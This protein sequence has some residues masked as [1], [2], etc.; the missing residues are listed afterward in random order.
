MIPKDGYIKF[1]TDHQETSS[2]CSDEAISELLQFRTEVF[3]CGW[4]G[5]LPDGVGFGNLSMRMGD[6]FIITGNTTGQ[7][8]VLNSSHFARILNYDAKS[9]ICT[10]E[11]PLKPSSESGTHAVIY[12]VLPE[13]NVVLHIHNKEIW[14]EILQNGFYTEDNIEYGTPEMAEAVKTLIQQPEVQ[15]AGLF[16]M[17]GHEEGVVVF[18]NGIKS[19]QTILRTY[20]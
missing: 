16:A 4:I 3:D 17:R 9:N 18:G 14:Q 8:R 19:L 12:D 10:S 15:N 7:H 5:V 11:G 20:Y 1:T 13:I 6:H 2:V